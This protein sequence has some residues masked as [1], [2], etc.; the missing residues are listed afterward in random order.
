MLL[1]SPEWWKLQMEMAAWRNPG[2]RWVLK[3]VEDVAADGKQET[4]I[5]AGKL[6]EAA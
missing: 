6:G 3:T 1:Q 4:F 5:G 2:V